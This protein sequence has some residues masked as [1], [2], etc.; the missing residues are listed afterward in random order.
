MGVVVR[1]VLMEMAVQ[2]RLRRLGRVRVVLRLR[3][4]VL[5]LMGGDTDSE[6]RPDGPGREAGDRGPTAGRTEHRAIVEDSPAGVKDK[7]PARGPS[8]D[9]AC[10]AGW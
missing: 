6:R 9:S 3:P 2:K 1:A 7:K 10:P 8:V 5:E 4:V